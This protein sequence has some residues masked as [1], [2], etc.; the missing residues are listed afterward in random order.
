MSQPSTASMRPTPDAS[1][2]VSGATDSRIERATPSTR[3]R[4]A[5]GIG[6]Y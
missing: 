5:S 2:H 4:T 6:S 3:A 1:C